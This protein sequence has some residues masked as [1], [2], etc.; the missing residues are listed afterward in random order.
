MIG[1]NS[2]I[3]I[4]L[5]IFLISSC[6]EKSAYEPEPICVDESLIDHNTA[7][8]KIYDPVCGCDGNTYSNNCIAINSGVLSFK[9]GACN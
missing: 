8:Y 6:L 2:M 7:C 4:I 9:E 5:L 1:E 3:L